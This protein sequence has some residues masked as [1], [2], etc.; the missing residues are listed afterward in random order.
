MPYTGK[1]HRDA[2]GIRGIDGVLVLE[3]TSRLDYRRGTRLRSFFDNIRERHER[4]RCEYR[5]LERYICVRRFYSGYFGAVYAAHLPRAN[6]ER[7]AALSVHN[8]VRFYVLAHREREY[9]VFHFGLGRRALRGHLWLSLEHLLI[10]ALNE[11]RACDRAHRLRRFFWVRHA[12]CDKNTDVRFFGK[13][14]ER[15]FFCV[16]CDDDLKKY[17]YELACAIGIKHAVQGDDAAERR[18]WIARKRFRVRI[19]RSCRYS[20]TARIHMLDDNDRWLGKFGNA[21]ECRVGVEKIVV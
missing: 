17:L 3:G 14:F 4:I 19:L 15:F 18:Y 9:E 2:R 11:N 8:G 10:P 13:Y 5:A 6:A 20:Y 12:A 1:H 7:G 16:G 21:L